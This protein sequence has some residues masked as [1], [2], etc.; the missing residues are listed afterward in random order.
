MD[1]PEPFRRLKAGHLL[2]TLT[3]IADPGATAFYFES[4]GGDMLSIFLVRKGSQVQGFVNRCPHQGLP[5]NSLPDDFLTSDGQLLC[6]HH[7][8]VFDSQ[9]GLCTQ[10]PCRDHYLQSVP[11]R[12]ENGQVLTA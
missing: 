5:L 8:A 10:G 11:V 7:G 6:C 3:Q 12:V 4:P 9:S 2:C 1:K